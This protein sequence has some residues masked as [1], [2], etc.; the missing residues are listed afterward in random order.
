MIITML[1]KVVVLLFDIKE[2]Y[3]ESLINVL[4]KD[5]VETILWIL[6]QWLIFFCIC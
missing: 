3:S 4:L 6:V 2:V 5:I 1:R